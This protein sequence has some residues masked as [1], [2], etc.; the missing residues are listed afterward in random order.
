MIDSRT[1]L[2]DVFISL[3]E[4]FITFCQ[5]YD[6]QSV[7]VGVAYEWSGFLSPALKNGSATTKKGSNVP[8]KFQLTGLA[9]GV[10]DAV[11]QL[12]IAPVV[13]GVIGPESPATS[14]GGSNNGNLF[15]YDSKNGQYVYNLNTS[16]LS[17][18][19]YHLRVD[20]GD[21]VDRTMLI[22]LQ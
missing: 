21:G 22:T 3:S 17:P 7:N 2:S 18:G 1:F 19:L 16:G 13:N 9:S 8:V 4:T 10:T 14:I 15:R 20:L 5:R 12:Y 6:D 11:A